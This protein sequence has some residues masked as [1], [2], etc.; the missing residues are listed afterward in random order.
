MSGPTNRGGAP[1]P[2]DDEDT[3][4][5]GSP[6]SAVKRVLSLIVV[7]A[8]LLVA[9]GGFAMS[10][11]WLEPLGIGSESNDSQ[12]IAAVERTQEVSLLSLAVQGIIEEKRAREIFG[13]GVPGSTESVFVQYNFKAKLGVDGSGVQVERTGDHSYRISVPEFTFIG[14]EEPTFKVAAQDSGVLSW[15]TP[16]IDQV[17][18]VNELLN[19]DAK[20][21]YISDNQDALQDQTKVFYDSLIQGIDP[22]AATTYTFD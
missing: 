11:G 6:V 10:R 13:R 3:T 8:L 18:M 15:I 14:Y 22:D 20:T 21:T 5:E 4:H 7:V 17:E 2:T 16:D 9:A 12:V 19:D 1:R